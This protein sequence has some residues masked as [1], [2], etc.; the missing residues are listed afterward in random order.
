M[1]ELREPPR[2]AA[3]RTPGSLHL[4]LGAQLALLVL[5]AALLISGRGG[6]S[7]SAGGD[8]ARTRLTGST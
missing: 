7:G 8:P 3:R 1:I 6:D 5:L 2:E 4:L